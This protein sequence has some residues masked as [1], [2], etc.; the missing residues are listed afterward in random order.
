MRQRIAVY[1]GT[2]DPVHNGHLKV[3]EAIVSAFG[4]D[5]MLFVPAY[6]PPHKRGQEIT[7]PFHR[8]AML[9]LATAGRERMFVSAI[10][11]EAP[12]RPY[13]IETLQ[14]LRNEW[15]ESQLFF[16]MGADSF[17]DVVIW[18]EY[19]R[20]LSEYNVIVATRTG[21]LDG[22]Q[23]AEHLDRDLQQRV[24]D[25]RRQQLPRA[26]DLT[27]EHIYL[28]DYVNVDVSATDVRDAAE[29]GAKIDHLVPPSAA[30]YIAKYGLY[31]KK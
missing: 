6:V 14:T 13:T 24:V 29:R 30:E 1:G 9:A 8:M 2:F 16:L 18:R 27:S 23:P 3:A 15:P 26:A 10:E 11:L 28:T 7:S 21:Y 31:Q 22:R 20:I 25:L 17:K 5:R 19:E 12:A 4:M